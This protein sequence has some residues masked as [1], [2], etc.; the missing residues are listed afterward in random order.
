M[1]INFK[2]MQ[3]K[4]KNAGDNESSDVLAHVSFT[5]IDDLERYFTV[6][7]F[8]IRKSKYNQEPYLMGPSRPIKGGGFF[9]F[10]LIDR[11]LWKMMVKEALSKF[12][13]SNIPIIEED[14]KSGYSSHY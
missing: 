7:G 3:C 14:G 9:K 11:S 4:V 1:E 2:K 8:T 13:Y 5:F 12:E 6:S 10:T